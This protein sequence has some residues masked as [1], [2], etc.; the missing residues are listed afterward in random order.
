MFNFI[1]YEDEPIFRDKY[2]AIIEKFIGESNL[3]YDV[4]EIPRYSEKN[5]E[6]MINISG[7][8][9][10]IL[11]IEVPG[12]SG[13]DLA[14]EIRNT[15]DWKSQIII[16]TSHE[17]LKNFDYQSSMLMLAFISKFYNIDKELYKTIS[18]AHR[19]LT[20]NEVISFQKGGKVY[21]IRIDDILFL[22]KKQEDSFVSVVTKNKDY[23]TDKTLV[24]WEKDLE[25]DPRFVRTHRNYIVNKYNIRTFDFEK[26]EMMFDN[27]RKVLISRN[28]KKNIK[29]IIKLFDE[30]EMGK[31]KEVSQD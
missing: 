4:I 1:I 10:Y 21:Q 23:I 14:R 2:F 7:N 26:D 11:D 28:Y 18:I 24:Q 19:I 12:K 5:Y 30:E 8:N 27:K 6:K 29:S 13:L 15:G 9:I 16:V 22:E 31:E 17:D 25:N 20:S 3:A